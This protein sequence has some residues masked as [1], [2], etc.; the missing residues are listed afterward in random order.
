[1]TRSSLTESSLKAGFAEVDITPEPGTGKIGHL[2]LVV[3]RTVADPLVATICV[4]EASA[5]RI[6]LIQLDTLSVSSQHVDDI[7]RAIESAHGFPGHRIMVAA[8]HNHAGAA[9]IGL[10]DVT[11]DHEYRGAVTKRLVE[12]FGEAIARL[13]VAELCFGRGVNFRIPHNRRVVMR[14]GTVKT[15]GTFADAQALHIE[16]PVDPELVGIGLRDRRR[17]W[18][19][20]ILNFACHPTHH[21]DDEAFSAGYPG[22]TRRSLRA[23]GI[24]HVVFLNGAL[25]NIHTRDPATGADLDMV[26]VG[27]EL[28]LQTLEIL[29]DAAWRSRA[30]VR[31][32]SKEIQLPL[33]APTPDQVS[34]DAPGAQRNVDPAV[35]ERGIAKLLAQM[36]VQAS[37]RAE[38]QVHA[39]DELVLAGIPAELFVEFGLAIKE[40]ASPEVAVI[41][42]L[43]N[44]M[45]GYVPTAA[46]FARGGYET[47]FAPWSKLAPEAGQL[48]TDAAVELVRACRPS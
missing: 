29:N 14:N 17:Q 48:I 13:V 32:T 20:C 8:S 10:G 24:P 12:G 3:G 22:V 1:M 38:V 47:T 9:V 21:L 45:V 7:R 35:Y 43:A 11:A 5:E 18:L 27:Q 6:A 28:A 37:E 4:I 33:R 34:G 25:G 46:A 23:A 39:I 41:V 19:G 15:H 44:G 42:G 40:R 31:S 16:G 36:R 30:R 26:A 2:K